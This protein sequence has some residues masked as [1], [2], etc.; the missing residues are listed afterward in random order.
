MD[1]QN[2]MHIY[3]DL[4]DSSGSATQLLTHQNQ[5]LPTRASGHKL[6]ASAERL[7]TTT[8]IEVPRLKML[9]NQSNFTQTD[10]QSST[11]ITGA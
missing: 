10:F 6:Y 11:P 8:T 4:L 1:E 9:F 3:S 5:Q 7:K 2:P